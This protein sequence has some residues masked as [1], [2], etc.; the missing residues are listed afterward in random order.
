M[1]G[2]AV[3][4]E[5]RDQLTGKAVPSGVSYEQLI[6]I[7]VDRACSDGLQLTGEGGLL[8]QLTKRVLEGEI[9]DH[10]GGPAI[11]ARR[12]HGADEPGSDRQGPAPLDD[13][14]EG[15]VERLPDRLRRSAHP[16]QPL[17]PQKPRSA[18]KLTHPEIRATWRDLSGTLQAGVSGLQPGYESVLALD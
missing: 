16:H 6:A 3:E 13:A 14:L 17:P 4:P 2:S 15:T 11:A 8:Q 18:V 1:T 7:L 9:T 10:V 5:D 12:L